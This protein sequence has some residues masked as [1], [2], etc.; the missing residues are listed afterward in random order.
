MGAGSRGAVGVGG[1]STAT[2]V[3]GGMA[4]GMGAGRGRG[5]TVFSFSKADRDYFTR[6]F[7]GRKRKTVR[8]VI[9]GQ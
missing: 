3:G 1:R 5:A 2:G 7:M 4:G 6:Q 8:K 9:T